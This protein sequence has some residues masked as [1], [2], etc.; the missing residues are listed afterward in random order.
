MTGRPFVLAATVALCLGPLDLE[1]Q[2]ASQLLTQG[3]DAYRGLDYVAAEAFLRRSLET[4]GPEPDPSITARALSYLGA[5]YVFRDLADSARAVFRRLVLHDARNR[6]DELVFPPQ[7]TNLFDAV[8]DELKTVT[9]IVPPRAE[10]RLGQDVLPVALYASSFHRTVV[11]IEAPDGR[12]ARLLYR[13]PIRDSLLLDWDGFEASGGPMPDGFYRLAVSSAEAS[14]DQAY[15]VGVT[16]QASLIRRDTLSHPEPP[17][18]SLYL[19]ER[20]RP[21]RSWEA[22]AGGVVVGTSVMLLPGALASEA[23]LS[24]TRIAVGAAVSV[25]GVI[26]FFI[27]RPGQPLLEN[28]RH[29]ETVRQDWERAVRRIADE[30]QLRRSDL[31]LAITTGVPSRAETQR[32]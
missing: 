17:A 25:A 12:T 32:P 27:Q 16:L 11:G 13:G 10:L 24:S 31:R 3:V 20:T 1:A 5:S 6:L 30:N 14:G 29:N 19:P 18:D 7:V 2:T 8:R 23:D 22:L 4:A 9:I 21:G 26:G 15:S 28:V